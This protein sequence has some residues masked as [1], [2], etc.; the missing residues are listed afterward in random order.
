[1]GYANSKTDKNE[2]LRLCKERK[3]FIKQA[4]DS[5]YALAAANVSYTK[6][7]RKPG[8]LMMV[9]KSG[10]LDYWKNYF[11]T[12]NSDIFEIIDYAIMVA[13]SDCPKELKLR[14]DRMAER[15]FSCKF[16]W[17]SGCDRVEL[18]VPCGGGGEEDETKEEDDNTITLHL[19]NYF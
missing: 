9:K 4:I 11:R 3:R 1:M 16:S 10:S 13:A 15:L 6:S 7:K 12:V 8:N 5:R 17:C 19:T 14:R 2:A 18:S